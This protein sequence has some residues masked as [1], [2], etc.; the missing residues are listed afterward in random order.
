MR[1]HTNTRKHTQ[2]Y[3]HKHPRA[4]PGLPS[5]GCGFAASQCAAAGFQDAA[6]RQPPFCVRRLNG[7]WPPPCAIGAWAPP[8]RHWCMRPPSCA[9]GAWAPPLRHWCMGSPPVPLVHGLPS[10]AIGAWAPL[11]RHWCMGSPPAPLLHEAPLLRHWCVGS[12][13]FQAPRWS[14]ACLARPGPRVYLPPAAM[15]KRQ[16]SRHACPAARLLQLCLC[17][18]SWPMKHPQQ[19]T[20]HCKQ[21][22]IIH[23]SCVGMMCHHAACSAEILIL[24][25]PCTCHDD[26]IRVH[27][28]HP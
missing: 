28:S 25:R 27:V 11:L 2:T 26:G 23:S 14:V 3:T 24:Q 1:A 8:L 15:F 12:L 16:R 18:D 6:P 4:R 17:H 10:C 13:L 9:I 20:V 7:A 19:G 22:Y 5:A 21:Q